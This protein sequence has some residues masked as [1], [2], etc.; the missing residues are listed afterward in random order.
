MRCFQEAYAKSKTYEQFIEVKDQIISL[1]TEKKN[2]KGDP[3]LQKFFNE[4]FC[5]EFS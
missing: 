3:Y 5:S 1:T 2:E 4:E